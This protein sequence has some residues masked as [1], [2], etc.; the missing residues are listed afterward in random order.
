MFFAAS[1]TVGRESICAGT[2]ALRVIK[3]RTLQGKSALT[4]VTTFSLGHSLATP[5]QQFQRFS[6][7]HPAP[8][9]KNCPRKLEVGLA[10]C[11]ERGQEIPR[12]EFACRAI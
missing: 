12:P 7:R 6:D 10:V 8:S 2:C 1:T 4:L 9:A 5:L 3:T 11:R